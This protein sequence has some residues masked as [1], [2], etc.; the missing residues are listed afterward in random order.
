[1]GFFED[2]Q[3]NYHIINEKIEDSNEGDERILIIDNFNIISMLN[4][5]INNLDIVRL[6]EN[7]DSSIKITDYHKIF[8]IDRHLSIKEYY[9]IDSD[10][11]LLKK[12]EEF[13]LG[14]SAVYDVIIK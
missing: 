11:F 13:S 4:K 14:S 3:R 6:E 1:M 7:W 2:E 8:L 12:N 5:N 10:K 9:V